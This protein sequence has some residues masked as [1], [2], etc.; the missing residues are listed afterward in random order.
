M[1]GFKGVIVNAPRFS[2]ITRTVLGLKGINLT[3]KKECLGVIGR[4]GAE[5][6]HVAFLGVAQPTEAG[7]VSGKTH[8]LELAPVFIQT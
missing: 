8:L 6:T 7:L 4:N 2:G 3:V 5:K 1:P